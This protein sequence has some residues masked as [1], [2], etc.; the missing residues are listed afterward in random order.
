MQSEVDMTQLKKTIHELEA[1]VDRCLYMYVQ[2]IAFG[3]SFNLNLQSQSHWSFFNRTWQKRP[4]ELD[5][6]LRFQ[7]QEMAL[8]VR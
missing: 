1:A 2:H 8:Q 5:H 6:G 3:V 7:I 4:R